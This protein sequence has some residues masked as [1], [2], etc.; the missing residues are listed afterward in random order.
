M[1]HACHTTPTGTGSELPYF[2]L[3]SPEVPQRN[4]YSGCGCEPDTRG[5]GCVVSLAS[6]HWSSLEGAAPPH[7]SMSSHQRNGR[8][9]VTWLPQEQ[10]SSATSTGATAGSTAAVVVVVGAVVQS[11]NIS[12]HPE[13]AGTTVYFAMETRIS[14]IDSSAKTSLQQQQQQQ[15][16][17][18]LLIDTGDGVWQVSNASSVLCLG[19][20]SSERDQGEDCSGGASSTTYSSNSNHSSGHAETETGTDAEAAPA[21]AAATG[22]WMMRSYQATLQGSGVARFAVR[23]TATATA[24]AAKI[25]VV[26]STYE[27]NTEEEEHVAS[28]GAL[29]LELSGIAVAEIGA[30]WQSLATASF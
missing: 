1:A 2:G 15:Q 18:S 8:E 5:V 14:A 3:F 10:A 23:M 29:K 21:V 13:L 7:A 12:D 22:Q 9:T 24:P 27:Y 19:S 25:P 11:L 20:G 28:S 6:G 26:Q 17:L 30:R 16:Q 4:M